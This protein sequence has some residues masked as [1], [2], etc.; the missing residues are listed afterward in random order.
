[1]MFNEMTLETAKAIMKAQDDWGWEKFTATAA[2]DLLVAFIRGGY[3]HSG[4]EK[5]M[6]ERAVRWAKALTEELR[7]DETDRD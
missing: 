7:K 1:M 2:K 6:A 3:P 4:A 5:Q